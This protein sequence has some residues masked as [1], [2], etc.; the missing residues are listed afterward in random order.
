M[1]ATSIPAVVNPA[2]Q[3]APAPA[4]ESKKP[5][6]SE[7]R[8]VMGTEFEETVKNLMEMGFEREQVIKALKAAFNNP[9]RAT[10]YLLNVFLLAKQA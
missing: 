6:R 1:P 5:V 10:E 2:V 9:D 4:P 8:L 3:P 7:E